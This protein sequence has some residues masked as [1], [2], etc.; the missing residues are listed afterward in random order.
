MK[1]TAS[2]RSAQPF[3]GIQISSVEV[4]CIGERQWEAKLRLLGELK[5]VSCGN[6]HPSKGAAIEAALE[7]ARQRNDRTQAIF[8]QWIAETRAELSSE[9]AEI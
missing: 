2:T 5:P 3:H 4:E 7:S 1:M 6:R 8:E 9:P